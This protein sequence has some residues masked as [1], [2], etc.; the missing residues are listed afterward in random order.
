MR[1]ED[2]RLSEAASKPAAQA[3]AKRVDASAS[4][5]DDFTYAVLPAP[6]AFRVGV[7]RRAG[8]RQRTRLR[9]GKLVRLDGGFLCECLVKNR[10]STGCRLRLSE[11]GADFPAGVY[12]YDDQ[13]E[14][15]FQGRV[16]WRRERDVGLRLTPCSPSALHRSILGAMR[17]KFYALKR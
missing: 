5:G 10:S 12:Y 15:L 13:S 9:S 1:D 17:R 8:G 3:L 6:A 2:R 16:V 4:I 14:L 11:V 7:E